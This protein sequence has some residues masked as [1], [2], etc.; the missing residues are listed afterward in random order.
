MGSRAYRLL[1]HS[2]RL[3]ARRHYNGV[4]TLYRNHKTEREAVLHSI[5]ALF[6]TTTTATQ[7]RLHT[8]SAALQTHPKRPLHGQR[9]GAR[10]PR[11]L[12]RHVLS[13]SKSGT[14][15]PQSMWSYFGLPLSRGWSW[16]TA[17]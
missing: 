5:G 1:P 12:A 3:R 7:E 10:E 16:A 11:P 6:S 8:Y 2:L 13:A 9:L 4:S 17:R 14:A 15:Q